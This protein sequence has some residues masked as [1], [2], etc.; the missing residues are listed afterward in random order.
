MIVFDI[1]DTFGIQIPYNAN[2]EMQDFADRRLCR[3]AGEGR[4]G[5]L[6]GIQRGLRSAASG[7]DMAQNGKRRR[8]AV[9][10]TGVVSPLGT[11][12]E[13][14]WTAIKQGECGIGPIEG[15]DLQD[16]Y[17]KIG[18][19]GPRFRSQNP[20]QI[21]SRFS[22]RPLFAICGCRRGRGVPAIGS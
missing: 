13:K 4:P 10:G 1:E 9:T 3:R 21:Q 6:S 18:G 11:G 8:V 14:V 15:F 16:L 20:L 17:I 2:E 22:C 5:W 7:L 19:R 12:T